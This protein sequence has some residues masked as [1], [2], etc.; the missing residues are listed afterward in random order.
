MVIAALVTFAILLVAWILAPSAP[1]SRPTPEVAI[2]EVA[3]PVAA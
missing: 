2:S 3:E 1:R